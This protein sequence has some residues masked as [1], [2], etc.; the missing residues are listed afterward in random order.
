[1]PKPPKRRAPEARLADTE[2][3]PLD[4]SVAAWPVEE[5]TV[6]GSRIAVRRTPPT[7]DDAEPALFV[8]GLSGSALNWTDLAGILR[9]RLAIDAIDLPGHGSSQPAAKRN[10]TLTRNADL[11][12]G[13]LEQSGR[14]PVHLVGNSMGGAISI[15]VA[16]RRPDLIRTLTLVSP[17]VPD[18]RPRIYPLKND[19]RVA[20]LVVPVLGEW[21]MRQFTH[22]IAV[23]A[24][25]KGT[26]RLCF[27]D[28]SRFPQA[29]FEEAVAEARRRMDLPWAETAVLRSMRGLVRSQ[30]F[31]G[32][33]AWRAM[34]RITAPTLV[35]WGDTDRL[36]APDLAPYVAAAIPDSR[37]RVLEDIGHTAMMEDP[38]TTARLIVALL[39]DTRDRA[40]SAA[41]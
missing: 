12:I 25:V 40:P 19:P 8:H 31:R 26:I 32:R 11:V 4:D 30:F 1:M 33:A 27:A 9:D 20:L 6:A 24:R 5:V 15:L 35:V 14:G 2:L 39:D 29:R 28:R 36:V 16:S 37:L 13:Y 21:F 41:P 23:E 10:Y 17:A 22:R 38:V 34:A 3:L 7:T 18:R